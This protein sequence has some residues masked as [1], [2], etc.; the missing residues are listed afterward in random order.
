MSLSTIQSTI[1]SKVSAFTARQ[2]SPMVVSV[3]RAQSC[4][5]LGETSDEET[6]RYADEIHVAG[7]PLAGAHLTISQA[8]LL[9]AVPMEGLSL[10]N[11]ADRPTSCGG[12]PKTRACS[13]APCSTAVVPLLPKHED[14]DGVIDVGNPHL[15]AKVP[16]P[17]GPYTNGFLCCPG[18]LPRHV[19]QFLLPAL[20]H[21]VPV[22]LQITDIGALR[23]LNMVEYFGTGEIAVKRKVPWD[24]TPDGVVDQFDTQLRMIFELPRPTPRSFPEPSPLNRIVSSRGAYIVGNHIIV[25]NTYRSWA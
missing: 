22:Q 8:Q 4:G 20:I 3:R 1:C 11:D 16:I 7:L 23:A 18:D 13:P 14:A 24:S 19:L 10:F 17:L 9:L 2:A 25:G 15:F 6:V 5:R 12:P 21:H